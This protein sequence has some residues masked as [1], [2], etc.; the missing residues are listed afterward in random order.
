[1]KLEY[2]AKRLAQTEH[3]SRIG[4]N[5]TMIQYNIERVQENNMKKNKDTERESQLLR[6]RKSME[7]QKHIPEYKETPIS[8]NYKTYHD[9]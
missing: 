3:Q 5:V 2:S 8:H 1:M 4:Q 7:T 6:L 9:I